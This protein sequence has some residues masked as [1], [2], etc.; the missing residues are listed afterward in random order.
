MKVRGID[1]DVHPGDPAGAGTTLTADPGAAGPAPDERSVRGACAEAIVR[2]AASGA[3]SL[4]LPAFGLGAGLSPVVSG[5]ILVQEAIRAARSGAGSLRRI[6]LCCA[7]RAS[8]DSFEKT[9]QGYLRHLLDVLIWGPFVT[10]DALIEVRGGIVL[11]R[12]RN[13]PL[14]YALPGGFVDYGES[15]EE[16]VQREA[17]EETGLSLRDVEQF[18]TYSDPARDPRFHTI[19]TV[20]TA[21]ADGSPRAGDDAADVLVVAPEEAQRLTFAFDHGRIVADWMSRRGP[22]RAQAR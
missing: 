17:R 14:G 5:K 21:R 10:V 11:V 7:D 12:R 1:I 3:D 22:A 16:A 4:A 9:I 15:L 6:V 18:H 2:A 13:P 20:F 19:S 8:F